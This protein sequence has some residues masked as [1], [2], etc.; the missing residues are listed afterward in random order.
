MAHE[1]ADSGGRG[2]ERVHA[3]LLDNGPEAPRVGVR[4]D[5]FEHERGRTGGERAVDDVGVPGHPADIGGAPEDIFV[6]VIEHRV[7]REERIEQVAGGRVQDALGLAGRTRRVQDE[8]WILGAHLFEHAW[9][10]DLG[11]GDLVVPPRVAARFHIDLARATLDHDTRVHRRAFEQRLIGRDL[12]RDLAPAT[13]ALIGRD[14]EPRA[15]VL[16]ASAQRRGGEPAKDDRVDRTHTGAREHG[17]GELGDHRHVEG[18]AVA[19]LYPFLAEHVREATHLVVEL[20]VGVGACRAVVALPDE[21]GL[22]AAPRVEMPVEAVGR[23]VE[24]AIGEVGVVEVREPA[25]E[26]L[27]GRLHPLEMLE[28]HLEPVAVRVLH[29]AI[30]EFL[31]VV[32]ARDVRALHEPGRWRHGGVG[33]V[34]ALL[35]VGLL[36]H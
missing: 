34:L 19:T 26:R 12:E 1:R 36:G 33:T 21:R 25:F 4:G 27:G 18:N 24:R 16:D 2:V 3:V 6:M 32:H 14:E 31:V 10:A 20:L 13:D 30:V 11:R 28:G 5:A 35:V 23:D 22:V 8:E 29:G 15:A 17:D 9:L 7:E